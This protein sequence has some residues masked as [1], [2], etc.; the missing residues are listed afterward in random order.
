[1]VTST[2][3]DVGGLTVTV[4]DLP[5]AAEPVAN[6]AAYEIFSDVPS[7][8]FLTNPRAGASTSFRRFVHA[9]E[10]DVVSGTVP[11]PDD[12]PLC[13]PLGPSLSRS[14]AHRLSQ[15]T[16]A[17]HA[18][19]VRTM[20]D[21][22][23]IHRGTRMLKVLSARQFAGYL[24]GWL[25]QGFCHREYDIAHLR[26]PADL[27]ILHTDRP[28]SAD[29]VVFA[30]RWRAVDARDYAVPYAADFP[31]LTRMS[32]HARAGP[33]VLGTGF[34]PSN[35]HLIAEFV[36]ADLADLPL[37]ARAEL[38]AY[39]SDGTEV[40][41]YQYI[42]E[43]RTWGRVA[44]R[45]WRHLLDGVDGI[46]ADQEY[47]AI[48]DAPTRLMGE[49]RGQS[50]EAIADPRQ[51]E[52]LILAKVRALRHVV[53]APTRHTP[54]VIWRDTPCTVIRV[55]DGWLR[56]RLR[57]PDNDA[58]ERTGASCVERGLYE[59]WAPAT[60]IYDSGESTLRYH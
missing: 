27:A 38:I 3:A 36:T 59:T 21:T 50:Y 7:D 18:G 37:P 12:T 39:T 60:D 30:L 22:V 25:P 46:A 58:L 44:G 55:S 47:F 24:H 16:S 2:S 53:T 35:R 8:G 40:L 17:L 6:G 26:T 15:S 5:Y 52:F 51:D 43:Q 10:I 54:Q 4:A 20:R 45:Q 28:Q 31:G 57:R 23:R 42:A 56:L 48:P 32:P 49:H 1:M 11:R 19:T 41:L 14:H 29:D 33:P 34:A 9:T 13:V